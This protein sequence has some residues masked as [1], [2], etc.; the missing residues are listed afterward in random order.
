MPASAWYA[1]LFEVATGMVHGE[2]PLVGLPTWDQQIN[3]QST[4]SLVT[5]IGGNGGKS[6]ESLRTMVKPARF[7]VAICYGPRTATDYIAQAGPIWSH[8]L[9]SE[10]PA[11]LSISGSGMWG[12]LNARVQIP[13]TWTPNQ[14]LTDGNSIATYT[15]SYRDIAA[16]IISNAVARGSLPIDL[17]AVP[18]GGTQTMTYNGYDL[19]SAGQRLQ[20]LTQQTGGPDLYFRPYFDATG[21]I[22]W[23]SMI[24]NPTIPPSSLPLLFDHGSNLVSALTTADGSGL[25]TD[26]YVKGNGT[27]SSIKWSLA[28]DT[29]LITAGWPRLDKV[30]TGHSDESSQVVLDGY[31]AADQ[32]LNGSP[33]ETW[34]VTVRIDGKCPLGSYGPGVTAGY[35]FTA[36][37]W[38]LPGK[39]NQRLLGLASG[40]NPSQIKHLIQAIQGAA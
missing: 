1:K 36:H 26:S 32:V 38:I 24:G 34:D 9:S 21:K 5:P 12:M 25:A 31:A 13:S 28:S 30:D 35:N 2:L 18:D 22:R 14:G 10:K 29:S 20:E 11:Q 37:P 33:L 4:W 19:T 39:Y 23:Q 15:G 16:A 27:A 17:P 40:S 8:Q 7:G 3:Q 6:R